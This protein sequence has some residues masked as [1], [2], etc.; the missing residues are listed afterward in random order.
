MEKCVVNKQT[1]NNHII[2]VT[3]QR[4]YENILTVRWVNVKCVCTLINLRG[5]WKLLR[6]LKKH[7][8]LF[9]YKRD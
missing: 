2:I 6:T 7:N 1:E 4:E 9:V 8:Y 5:T 3:C